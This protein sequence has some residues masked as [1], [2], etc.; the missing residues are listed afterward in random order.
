MEPQG[1]LRYQRNPQKLLREAAAEAKPIEHTASP[2][3][4]KRCRSCGKMLLELGKKRKMAEWRE[5]ELEIASSSDRC[6]SAA[7]EDK[8]ACL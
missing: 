1:A 5:A 4:I 3:Q 7:T 6:G 8:G 2:E